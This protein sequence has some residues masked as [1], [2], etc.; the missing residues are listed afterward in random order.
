MPN[1]LSDLLYVIVQQVLP[2]RPSFADLLLVECPMWSYH[3]MLIPVLA[4]CMQV[5]TRVANVVMECQ[6]QKLKHGGLL[7]HVVYG[8]SCRSCGAEAELQH[9]ATLSAWHARACGFP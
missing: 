3:A 7:G 5:Y 9:M 2:G 4:G 6:L 8:A 1:G